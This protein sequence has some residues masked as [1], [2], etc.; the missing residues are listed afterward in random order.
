[1]FPTET[2]LSFLHEMYLSNCLPFVLPNDGVHHPINGIHGYQ[3][4]AQVN[5]LY[6]KLEQPP[7]PIKSDYPFQPVFVVLN[8]KSWT[9]TAGFQRFKVVAQVEFV[10]Q[11]ETAGA[12][13][14][15]SRLLETG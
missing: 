4:V 14:G 15:D 1:M 13:A 6:G 10:A 3:R 5:K 2:T 11:I 8:I 7:Q 9:L 12:E